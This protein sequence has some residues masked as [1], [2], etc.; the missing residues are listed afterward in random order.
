M[1]AVSATGTRQPGR[2]TAVIRRIGRRAVPIGSVLVL[3]A[4]AVLWE[5]LSRLTFVVPDVVETFETLAENLSD[6]TYLAHLRATMVAVGW[7]FAIG[8]ALGGF[9]GLVLGLSK[10]ARDMFEP[11]ILAL[12]GMPKIVLYPLILPVF[13][14]GYGSKI[15]MGALFCVFPVL[16]NVAAGVR[17]MP[18]V[19]WKLARSLNVGKR[20]LLISFV[21][22]AIRRPLLTGIRLAVS[23]A[24]VGV[25][26][27]EFFA[28]KE[29]LGRVVLRTYGAG[30]Y[31][32]MVATVLLLI[33]ISFVISLLLWR[34][35]KRVR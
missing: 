8:V 7:A 3:V 32:A 33:V 10:L 25:V 11:L 5:L 14:L 1:T 16:I 21:L 22:P 23:L 29:G 4:F 12:N 13:H 27:S 18:D 26:L 15:V 34:M 28:T 20:Q 6:A 30:D 19:Y 9:L 35:E 2:R 17:D 24:T 31:P